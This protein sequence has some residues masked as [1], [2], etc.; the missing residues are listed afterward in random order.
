M[1]TRVSAGRVRSIYAFINDHRSHYSVE[2][3]CRRK[4]PRSVDSHE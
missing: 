4:L 3:L 2:V 1:S